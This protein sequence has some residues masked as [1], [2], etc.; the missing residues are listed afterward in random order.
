[1]STRPWANVATFWLPKAGS[2][3]EEYED[4]SWIGPDGSPEGEQCGR[5]IRLAISDGASESMLASRW[6]RLLSQSFGQSL[7]NPART[8]A[9]VIKVWDEVVG[10]Y[11]LERERS[12]SPIQWYEEPGLARG[13]FA[14]LL[15]VELRR[16]PSLDTYEG[17]WRAIAV[18]DSCIF[19]IRDEQLNA[20]FPI[21]EPGAFGHSPPLVPSKPVD[22]RN[23]LDQITRHRG[24]WR[25]GDSFYLATDAL[26]AWFLRSMHLGER[27]WEALRDLGTEAGPPSFQD[28]ISELRSAG[29]MQ[30]DDVTLIRIDIW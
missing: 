2:G 22:P 5:H 26:A 14:T 27:P 25:S 28:W 10:N 15:A 29:A 21:T 3:I 20:S 16:P 30:N 9:K 18:G 4:A 23:V 17:T 1:V 8:M 7:A 12:G 19:Q 24:D 6:A 11:L 13:A